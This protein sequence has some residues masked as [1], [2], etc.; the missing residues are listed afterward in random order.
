MHGTKSKVGKDQR[1]IVRGPESGYGNS[2]NDS[3][4]GL[5]GQVT[6]P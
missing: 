4:N 2:P 5:L 1:E 3:S 6:I